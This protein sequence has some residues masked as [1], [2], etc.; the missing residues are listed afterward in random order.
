MRSCSSLARANSG[1][2]K[3]LVAI[4]SGGG[5]YAGY[6]T[7]AGV[8]LIADGS[9][10]ADERLRLCLTNDTATGVMRYADAG[11]QESL[12]ETARG[13]IGYLRLPPQ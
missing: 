6:M 4:H 11:Y 12:D 3:V 7:S 10:A 8:T 2:R 9:E 13:N 5:G 1:R